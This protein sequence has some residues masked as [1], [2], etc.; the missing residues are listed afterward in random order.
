MA[1]LVVAGFISCAGDLTEK[2]AAAS[3][4]NFF[5]VKEFVAQEKARMAG[6]TITKTVTVGGIEETKK[7]TEVDWE[8]E[9]A[10]FAQSNIDRPAMWDAY[11]C[12]TTRCMNYRQLLY[13]AVDSTKFTKVLQV[14]F[15][16]KS[17]PL[18]SVYS[19]VVKNG[20]DSYIAKTSQRLVWWDG[21]YEINSIQEA[22][23]SDERELNIQVEWNPNKPKPSSCFY[24]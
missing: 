24:K 2:N 17:T 4:P 20:F 10:P 18:D 21:G 12:D 5:N 1:L 15:L 22:I 14:T 6:K 19:L 13:K 3:D 16:D 7:L 23:L 9:L 11:K 8:L